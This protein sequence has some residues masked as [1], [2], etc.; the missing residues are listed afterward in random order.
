MFVTVECHKGYYVIRYI[1]RF[2]RCHAD[3]SVINVPLSRKSEMAIPLADVINLNRV[4]VQT[5]GREPS[6]SSSI[7][8]VEDEG[9]IV[10]LRDLEEH[11]IHHI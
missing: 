6:L 8:P 9:I 4:A 2:C 10:Y 11:L 1:N 3:V 7:A 5:D